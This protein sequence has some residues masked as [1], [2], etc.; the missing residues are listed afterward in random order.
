VGRFREHADYIATLR[1]QGRLVEFD[2][3]YRPKVRNWDDLPE[4]NVCRRLIASGTDRYREQL[5]AMIACK[6]ALTLIPAAEPADERQPFWAN[7]WFPVLDAI[8][9]TG[10]LVRLNPRRYVEVGSGNST[11]FAR[12]AIAHHGL[13]TEITSIDPHPRA[14]VEAIDLFLRA[15]YLQPLAFCYVSREKTETVEIARVGIV[16]RAVASPA[17]DP[18]RSRRYEEVFHSE[19]FNNKDFSMLQPAA[20]LT[21][22]ADRELSLAL[23]LPDRG[24]SARLRL[25][26][27]QAIAVQ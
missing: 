11:K 4:G 20:L 5:Q 2:Y 9:L 3:P 7:G 13:R 26:Q 1:G 19:I 25:R 17:F 21:G 27:C 15:C 18:R 12:W 22:R 8:C 10:M 24:R 16:S 6:D 23:S 14:V